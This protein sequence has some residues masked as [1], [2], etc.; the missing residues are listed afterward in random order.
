MTMMLKGLH[1]PWT[2]LLQSVLLNQTADYVIALQMLFFLALGNQCVVPSTA[3]M[4]LENQSL[5][6]R[7]G[8]GLWCF[9]FWLR[10]EGYEQ[11]IVVVAS[12]V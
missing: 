7:R 2:V 4:I 1:I 5:F 9:R 3:R 8:Q 11:G 10:G 6:Q 12:L